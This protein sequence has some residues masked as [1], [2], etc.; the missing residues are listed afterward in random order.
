MSLA[1]Q[2]ALTVGPLAGYLYLVGVWQS[3][4]HPRVV[5]GRVDFAVLAFGVS[6]L[7]TVGPV[8]QVL[9]ELIFGAPGAIGWGLW[10]LFL[11]LWTTVFAG[12]ASRRIVVYNVEPGPI[13]EAIG[14]TLAELPGPTYQATLTGFESA[15][16]GR[17][18][19]VDGSLAFRVATIDVRGREP[20]GLARAIRG[21]LR[22]RLR[23]VA[24]R[25]TRV[26]WALFALSW[27]TML[28]PLLSFLVSEPRARAAMRAIWLKITG[29]A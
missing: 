2:V 10:L 26:T 15:E 18:V 29:R 27:L 17:A 24:A 21:P 4:R 1:T 3:G 22:D 14:A 6:G 12:L 16:D 19:H 25:P 20:E 13:R 5:S 23:S 28:S 11:A 8:G 9:M 7:V